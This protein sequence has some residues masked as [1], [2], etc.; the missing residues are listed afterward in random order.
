MARKMAGGRRKIEMKLIPS[1]SAR[2]V[3]FS[4][5]RLG[6]FKK[7]NE[8]CILT[9][10]EIGIVV[11]S[12]SGKAFSFGHPSVDTIVQRSLYE[13]PM[14]AAIGQD[15][16]GSIV[17]ALSQE[18]TKMCRQLG[19]EKRRGK[20]LK[21]SAMKCQRPYWL[22]APIHELN[23]DQVLDSK[24]CMEE[25]RAKIAKRVNE[26]SVEG[27]ASNLASSAKF[28]RGIDLNVAIPDAI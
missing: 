14:P 12:P 16:H 4:K 18:Y 9:G 7:A 11:F 15:S 5:R 1:K 10:C 27:S 26:L 24:K 3:A 28:V 6:I 17:P 19:A 13:S 2:Q 20:E 23:L 8:L 25:L 21:E 22:D